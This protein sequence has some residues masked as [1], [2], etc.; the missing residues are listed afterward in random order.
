MSVIVLVLTFSITLSV[1]SFIFAAVSSITPS[2]LPSSGT[3]SSNSSIFGKLP[4][5][6]LSFNFFGNLSTTILILSIAPFITSKIKFA[7][8]LMPFL[9][10]VKKPSLIPL[11]NDKNANNFLSVAIFAL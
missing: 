8:L 9:N 1:K 7:A 3:K 5:P 2:N 10:G 11:N 4:I 6:S